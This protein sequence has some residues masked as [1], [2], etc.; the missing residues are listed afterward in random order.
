MRLHYR[1][2]LTGLLVFFFP[3]TLWVAALKTKKTHT[4][5]SI[6]RAR[7]V[8]F[9]PSRLLFCHS[10]K[11]T[12]LSQP[13][14]ALFS[15]RLSAFREV[16]CDPDQ[17]FSEGGINLPIKRKIID[18]FH[19]RN[20]YNYSNL[21]CFNGKCALLCWGLNDLWDKMKW[22]DNEGPFFCCFTS[23]CVFVYCLLCCCFFCVFLGKDW[24]T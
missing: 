8:C 24:S 10:S 11:C 12:C 15:L 5:R 6:I 4:K 23:P 13:M 3:P 17:Y 16:W 14:L 21:W 2:H 1:S 7:L 18:G 19:H 20:E 22:H 9:I